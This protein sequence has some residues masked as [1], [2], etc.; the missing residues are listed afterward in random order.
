MRLPATIR[1]L[2]LLLALWF[3]SVS[4][5]LGC[6]KEALAG[7]ALASPS[8]HHHPAL[9]AATEGMLPH[10]CCR[11]EAPRDSEPPAPG[12][13]MECCYQAPTVS[14][15]KAKA[16]RLQTI[17]LLAA[18]VPAAPMH[19]SPDPPAGAI[20]SPDSRDAYLLH[21]VLRI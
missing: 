9:A 17:T 12:S 16:P 5:L 19:L 21:R 8:D 11:Q 1:L 15:E 2:T 4:C 14:V 6:E 18:G 13:L 7:I 3:A 20:Y 10:D